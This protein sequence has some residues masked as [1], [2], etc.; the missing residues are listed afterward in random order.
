MPQVSIVLPTYNRAYIIKRALQSI[1]AQTYQDFELLVIDDGST[2]N[3]REVVESFK[4]PRIHFI[5]C[6]HQGGAAARNTGIREAKGA[7][8]AFQDSDDEWLPSKLEKQVT[9]LSKASFD[10][11]VVYTGCYKTSKSGEKIYIPSDEIKQKEGNVYKEML[12]GNF[13]TNQVALVR[14]ECFEQLGGYDESLPGMHEL[15]LWLRISKK[16]RFAYIPEP[17]VITYF[18][19]DSITAHHD[20]RL[21]GREI[22]FQKHFREFQEYPSIFAM[23]AFTIGNTRALRG[24][25]WGAIPYLWQSWKTQPL[26]L[27]YVGAFLLSLLGSQRIY[28]L[29]GKHAK[30]LV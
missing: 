4:D 15:D 13:V 22:I 29:F 5:Q 25:V 11:G 7:Y 16:Y 23:H 9:L 28:R 27:K 12:I 21:R 18:T 3:T 24:N 20:F 6:S 19:K 17:L 1:L 26:K 14:K 30:H 8:I 2:D 10:I